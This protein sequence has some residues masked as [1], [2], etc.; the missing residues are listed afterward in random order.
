[1][2][3]A[4]PANIEELRKMYRFYV[5]KN[6]DGGEGYI[7][8]MQFSTIWRLVTKERGNLYKEMQIFNK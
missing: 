6:T 5:K 4:S 2:N 3:Y 8:V 7:N 1:M